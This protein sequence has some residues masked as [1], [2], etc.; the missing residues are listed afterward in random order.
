[1]AEEKRSLVPD[2]RELV[3][4][5]VLHRKEYFLHSADIA[6]RVQDAL[7]VIFYDREPSKEDIIDIISSVFRVLEI[8]MGTFQ[9]NKQIKEL[10]DNAEKLQ[11]KD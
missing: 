3:K 4:Q 5:A 9:I 8:H 11:S 7:E 6:Q 2:V 1:M 10:M